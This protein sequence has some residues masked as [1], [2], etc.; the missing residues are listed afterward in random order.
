MKKK[1]SKV[2]LA[3]F[4]VCAFVSVSYAD[5]CPVDQCKD[6]K[7]RVVWKVKEALSRHHNK[8]SFGSPKIEVAKID[9]RDVGRDRDMDRDMTHFPGD[10]PGWCLPPDNNPPVENP[11]PEPATMLLFGAGIAG[12]A[13]LRLRKKNR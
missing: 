12:I 6:T 4:M 11:V 1:I 7:E 3:S 9:F 2:L 13:G 10:K 5:R 8:Q